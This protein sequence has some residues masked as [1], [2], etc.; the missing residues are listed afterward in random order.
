MIFRFIFSGGASFLSHFSPLLLR[1]RDH[2]TTN[3]ALSVKCYERQI[4]RREIKN[5]PTDILKL[6]VGQKTIVCGTADCSLW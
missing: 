2:E 4:V 1:S 3:K 6:S 5:C